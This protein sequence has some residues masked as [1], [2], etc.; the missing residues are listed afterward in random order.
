M[1]QKRFILGHLNLIFF[2]LVFSFCQLAFSAS[3]STEEKQY[4]VKFL[5]TSET[6]SIFWY[7]CCPPNQVLNKNG[8]CLSSNS[9]QAVPPP[10]LEKRLK[11]DLENEG[12]RETRSLNELQGKL[13]KNFDYFYNYT[14]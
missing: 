3:V 7:K 13:Y 4:V 14:F 9:E 10:P 12:K 2:V 6:Q 11:R 1:S 8:N 5:S